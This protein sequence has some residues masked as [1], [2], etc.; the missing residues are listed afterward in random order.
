MN[1]KEIVQHRKAVEVLAARLGPILEPELRIA[2]DRASF[3]AGVIRSFSATWDNAR[4]IEADRPDR[5]KELREE[6]ITLL[7]N[8]FSPTRL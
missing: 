7:V 8:T 3:T 1:H 4:E 6:A 2:L 5:A